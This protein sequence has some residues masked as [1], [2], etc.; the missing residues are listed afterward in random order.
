LLI[1]TAFTGDECFQAGKNDGEIERSR[2]DRF[3]IL[4]DFR[5]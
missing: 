4:V 2:F 1:T 5:F 3:M